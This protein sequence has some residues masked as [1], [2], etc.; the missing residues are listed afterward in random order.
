M[1]SYSEAA[2]SCQQGFY[3][4]YCEFNQNTISSS[5]CKSLECLNGKNL[6]NF[7]NKIKQN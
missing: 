3:G 6:I 4:K 5:S 1:V 2:C 7:N